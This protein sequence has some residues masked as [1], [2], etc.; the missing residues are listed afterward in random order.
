MKLALA[1]LALVGLSAQ[2]PPKPA[3]FTLAVMTCESKDDLWLEVREVDPAFKAIAA[4]VARLAKDFD[5]DSIEVR[6]K[7]AAAIQKLGLSAY[8]AIRDERDKTKSDTARI[9]LDAVMKTLSTGLPGRPSVLP[10]QRALS[11]DQLKALVKRFEN[12]GVRRLQMPSIMLKENSRGT[13]FVGDEIPLLSARRLKLDSEGKTMAL[14]TTPPG[15]EPKVARPGPGGGIVIRPAAPSFKIGFQMG[16]HAAFA[17]PATRSVRLTIDV[18]NSHAVR[19]FRERETPF[20]IVSDPEVIE[21]GVDLAPVLEAGRHL[22]AGPF[23]SADPKGEPWW[24][25]IEC[26]AVR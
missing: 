14:D 26:E 24:L 2:D 7:A 25:V 3:Q 15:A 5:S 8:G 12:M 13:V 10:A 11:A 23:P 19:P 1:V 4:D 20:G 18:T 17:D 6:N 16:V 9:E 22:V 21:L